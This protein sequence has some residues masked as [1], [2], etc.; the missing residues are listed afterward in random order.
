MTIEPKD[1]SLADAWPLGRPPPPIYEVALLLCP[2]CGGAMGVI[3]LIQEPKVIDKIV[4]QLRAKGL[5]RA[6]RPVGDRAAGGRSARPFGRAQRRGA[7]RRWKRGCGVCRRAGG[8]AQTAALLEGRAIDVLSSSIRRPTL[9]DALRPR[10]T[11]RVATTARSFLLTVAL[12][13]AA[14]RAPAVAAPADQR[15]LAAPTID[16]GLYNVRSTSG[17]PGR[18]GP[19][20]SSRRGTPSRSSSA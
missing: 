11:L 12:G 6:R 16:V 4:R 10:E 7:R 14:P 15:T 20:S 1:V 17:G 5:G 9:L 3:A 8:G 19:T 18:N 13:A 2:T